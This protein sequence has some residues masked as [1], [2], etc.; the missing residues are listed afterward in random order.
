MREI[1]REF[2]N[3]FE[4]ALK[5]IEEKLPEEQAKKGSSTLPDNLLN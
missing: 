1:E 3:D 4:T 2:P 5:R